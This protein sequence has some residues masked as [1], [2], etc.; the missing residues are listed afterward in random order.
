MDRRQA[1]RLVFASALGG[2][3]LHGAARAG[4]AGEERR[5]RGRLMVD[6][7]EGPWLTFHGGEG[8]GRGKTVVLISGDQEYRSEETLPQLARILAQ[9]HGFTCVV[10]FTIDPADGTI[11]P[12]VNNI[13]GLEKLRSADLLVLFTRFLDLPDEQ[14]KPIVEY[15]E[16]GR[17]IVALRTSTHAFNLSSKTYGR[18]S[19]RSEEPGYEGGFGRQVLGETWVA[20]HGEHGVEGTRGVVA[21]GQETHPIVRGIAPNSIF[22]T[23]DVYTVRL[24][25]PG[26]S[27]PLV[28][29][30]VTASLAPDSPPVLA[31][32]APMMPVA[33]TKSYRGRAGRAAR[34]FTT[35]MGASQDFA[36]EGTRRMLVN[37]V[38][39]AAGLERQIPPRADVALV[40]KY[41]PTPFRFKKNEEWKPGVRPAD[42]AK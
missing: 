7:S 15:V 36:Y 26:D 6:A 19:W 16:S 42:L 37:A 20:H 21:P 8:P 40:G 35:T 32:N 14:M 4:A 17:P 11:N 38:Y 12:T 30:E 24:P 2:A 23:T 22:G 18:Y 31:K 39:W 28:L 41:E 29:G 1:I 3:A 33:W 5:E 25:L 10:L 27:L 13:P 9:R 34:V